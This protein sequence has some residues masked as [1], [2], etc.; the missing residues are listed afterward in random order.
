MK[1]II[2]KHRGSKW[3]VRGIKIYM[4]NLTQTQKKT[5]AVVLARVW[6]THADDGMV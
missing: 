1:H 6:V 5:P 4:G 2:D 3:L